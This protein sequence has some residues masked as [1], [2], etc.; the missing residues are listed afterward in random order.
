[1]LSCRS[2]RWKFSQCHTSVTSREV[3]RN[4][5]S[6][7]LP[8][9]VS[10]VLFSQGSKKLT[11]NVS[12]GLEVTRRWRLLEIPL[13]FPLNFT[14]ILSMV[15]HFP[16]TV[17]SSLTLSPTKESSL[18]FGVESRQLLASFDVHHSLSATMCRNHVASSLAPRSPSSFSYNPPTFK[19][20]HFCPPS[21][22]P[23]SLLFPRERSSSC[24]ERWTSWSTG[25]MSPYFVLPEVYLTI[26]L[27][28][29]TYSLPLSF[30]AGHNSEVIRTGFWRMQIP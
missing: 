17:H 16:L 12:Y 15:Q 3:R 7:T 14:P 8:A 28:H 23:P 4:R 10:A 30:G 13:N 1:M 19:L 24:S 21:A 22:Q 6:F 18:G 29:S 26:A 11:V 20:A 25:C 2:V 9:E 5:K 27:L